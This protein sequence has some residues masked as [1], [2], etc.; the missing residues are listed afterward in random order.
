MSSPREAGS[1]LLSEAES[2]DQVEATLLDLVSCRIPDYAEGVQQADDAHLQSLMTSCVDD[3]LTK[4]LKIKEQI[5]TVYKMALIL[6]RQLQLSQ[7]R[8]QH[9]TNH[10]TALQQTNQKLRDELAQWH[11]TGSEIQSQQ[12]AL[13]H[14]V[15]SLQEEAA[16]ATKLAI[17]SR[18][19]LEEAQ[20][21]QTELEAELTQAMSAL[22]LARIEKRDAET[23]LAEFKLE[24][25]E[26]YSRGPKVSPTKGRP[27][28]PHL[29]KTEVHTPTPVTSM[30]YQGGA[31]APRSPIRVK[32]EPAGPK[33]VN[34]TLFGWDESEHTRRPQTNADMARPITPSD[35]DLDKV[36]RNISRFEPKPGCPNDIHLY[37]NDIDYY[38]RR[39]PLAT[40]DDRI[41]LIKITSSRDVSSFIERQPPHVRGNY[42][43]LCQALE[44]EFSSFST[45]LGLSAAFTVR[46]NRQEGPEQYYYRLRRAYF[47]FK[48]EPE[49]EE[50]EN[51]KVLF[52]QNLHPSTSH[53]LGVSAC[54]RTLTSR[55]L[56][57]LA[58]R[59]F[60]KVQQS[61][62]K[63]TDSEVLAVASNPC[64][65]L[66]GKHSFQGTD[67]TH[68]S[69]PYRQEPAQSQQVDPQRRR[70]PTYKVNRGQGRPHR[71]R[72]SHHQRGG[73]PHHHGNNRHSGPNQ[74]AKSPK[75]SLDKTLNGLEAGD[76][77]LILQ[78]VNQMRKEKRGNLNQGRNIQEQSSTAPHEKDPKRATWE[79]AQD[80]A[81]S[82]VLVVELDTDHSLK[83]E[84]PFLIRG[85][86]PFR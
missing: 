74:T 25:D 12:E 7:E 54:P 41:Y 46:Q 26:T 79:H 67:K 76:L 23:Q 21:Q 8:E 10:C 60:A 73:R 24:R 40:I 14:K 45:Q 62:G 13:E 2:V 68:G 65:E 66:E 63:K 57:D 33:K 83:E 56:R 50:D 3:H 36:A 69:R 59:G 75:S 29:F 43:A 81:P 4:S 49:M 85:E 72:A 70:S 17:Q 52:V 37:L 80:T 84:D 39:F 42:R 55:Q 47:G 19:K 77:E 48:N 61:L 51:F 5:D 78:W 20:E 82:A 86:L 38:L 11:N 71:G 22:R 6:W 35:R 34:R 27:A 32:P 44:A 18:G 16:T 31:E 58:L 15:K 28:T 1:P 9:A 30:G 64:M 53:H